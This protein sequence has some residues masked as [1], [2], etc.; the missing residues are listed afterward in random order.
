MT[1]VFGAAAPRGRG[2]AAPAPRVDDALRGA[3]I[4]YRLGA[5]GVRDLAELFKRAKDDAES[6]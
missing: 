1:D 6:A 3:G 2:T 5:R 4:E